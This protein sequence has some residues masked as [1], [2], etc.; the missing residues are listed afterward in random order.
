VIKS[1]IGAG[2]PNFISIANTIVENA[3]NAPWLRSIP[4]LIIT[5]VIPRPARNMLLLFT[6]NW[7]RFPLFR[8]TGLKIEV[9]T[10]ITMITIIKPPYSFKNF[11]KAVC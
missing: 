8:N 6:N 3:A 4:P 9:A 5:N 10:T 1:A 2:T 7:S 11:T